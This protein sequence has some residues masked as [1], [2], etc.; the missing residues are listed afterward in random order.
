MSLYL[1]RLSVELTTP[2][3]PIPEAPIDVSRSAQIRDIEASFAS[4]TDNFDLTTLRHPN[5]PNVT[6]VESY[7]V[8][9]DASI[10]ANAYDLFRFSERPGDR[11]RPPEVRR[12]HPVESARTKPENRRTTRGST[13]RCCGLWR[14]R[15][16]IS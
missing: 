1:V 13:V 9:P 10:W 2:S 5:K 14:Q 6:A 3:K 8:L 16:I 11:P 12:I 15:A 4:A 7:E